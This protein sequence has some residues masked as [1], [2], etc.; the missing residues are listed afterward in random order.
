MKCIDCEGKATVTDSVEINGVVFRR[1][2]CVVCNKIFY[3][4]ESEGIKNTE[5][6]KHFWKIRR[7]EEE[8]E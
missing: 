7:G 4:E 1:R 6:Y 2:K 5:L 8:A 3:T